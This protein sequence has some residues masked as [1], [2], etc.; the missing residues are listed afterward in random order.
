MSSYQQ[1]AVVTMLKKGPPASFWGKGSDQDKVERARLYRSVREL[2]RIEICGG[3]IPKRYSNWYQ[4]GLEKFPELNG[5][6]KLDEDFW[7]F[8][9]AR[10]IPPNPDKKF[11]DFSGPERLALLETALSGERRAWDDD[12]AGRASDWIQEIGR[13]H[14]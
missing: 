7:S 3:T 10:W 6:D 14:V 4:E 13:A 8:K 2:R 11:D 1:R 9:K 12:T 5:M